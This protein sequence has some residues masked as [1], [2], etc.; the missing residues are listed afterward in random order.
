MKLVRIAPDAL[1]RVRLAYV[2]LLALL[3]LSAPAGAQVFEFDVTVDQSFLGAGSDETAAWDP[4][5]A[6]SLF[7]PRWQETWGTDDPIYLPGLGIVAGDTVRLTAVGSFKTGRSNP[8]PFIFSGEANQS[9]IS[10]MIGL[11]SSDDYVTPCF[12]FSSSSCAFLDGSPYSSPRVISAID[13]GVDYNTGLMGLSE[14]A[15]FNTDIA[16]DFFISTTSV[17]VEVPPGGVY[18]WVAPHDDKKSTGPYGHLYYGNLPVSGFSV[19][20]ELVSIC[21]DGIPEGPEE[22][23]DGNTAD[24]DCCSATCT[25][26]ANGSSCSDDNL[27]TD[28]DLCDGAGACVAGAPVVCSNGQFC[29]G[30]ELC[31]ALLGCQP[32]TPPVPDDGVPCT[33]DTCDEVNDSFVFAP[34]D[35]QCDDGLFCNGD[36]VCDPVNNCV[37]GLPL[38]MD[39]GVVCTAD[40]CNESIDEIVHFPSHAA[41]DNMIFCDG[42]EVCDPVF[43]CR[44]GPPLVLDDGVSCTADFCNDVSDEIV[45]FPV[46]ASCDNGLFCDGSETCDAVNDC[47]TGTPPVADDGV[48]CTTGD[49]CD[50]GSDSIV[51]TP[52]HSLCD[53][54]LFCDGDETC[55]AVN[56]CQTGTP[57]ADD[58]GV[59]CT[60]GDACDE[61]S[62]SIV[63]LANDA[64][65]NDTNP[66]TADSCDALV[67]CG[68]EWI[69]G[70][71]IDPP[72]TE[73]PGLAG[74]G[75]VALALLLLAAGS[76]TVA[77]RRRS[78]T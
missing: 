25:F 53:N 51:G 16:E 24:G 39:D 57:P 56:D 61:G 41:C 11:F 18:L 13:S 17:E 3:T 47:Q 74:P 67:G 50:E 32:G 72:S 71:S 65:C 36:E 48:A 22:C 63:G 20:V 31:D 66:C 60:T 40:F 69:P 58:D 8:F 64:Q 59:A 28:I 37:L 78:E 62:D 1:G 14:A 29:D 54:G 5:P 43:N 38:D 73:V 70:C 15:S 12:G 76:V 55:D 68:N 19:Q 77:R 7:C 35:N 21:G 34:D 23:D 27:C 75:H 6:G 4:C 45:H 2:L 33:V 10:K 42:V 44:P 9:V 46:H 52:D 30:V 26:E 49:A